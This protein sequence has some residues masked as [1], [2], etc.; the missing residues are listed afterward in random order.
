MSGAPTSNRARVLAALDVPRTKH[1]LADITGLTSR[2]VTDA[3]DHLRS[4]GRITAAGRVSQ[5]GLPSLSTWARTSSAEPQPGPTI[6]RAVLA[7]LATPGTV[8][9]VAER[10]GLR[11]GQVLGAVQKLQPKG[12][13]VQVGEKHQG[14]NRPAPVWRARH[15]DGAAAVAAENQR[16]R[17]RYA[18]RAAAR[19]PEPS[20]EQRRRAAL[21]GVDTF[22]AQLRGRE[23]VS[24]WAG[25]V[26]SMGMGARA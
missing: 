19:V 2:Q 18:E 17:E 9:E 6:Q 20:D 25:L 5:Q 12:L 23:S 24:P 7:A 11:Y 13:I 16:R 10:S 21:E 14:G 15:H 22:I 4:T 1:Q 8:R 26:Q 3:L